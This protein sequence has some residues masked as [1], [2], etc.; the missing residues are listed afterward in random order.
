MHLAQS[1]EIY[2]LPSTVEEKMPDDPRDSPLWPADSPA[3]TS[4]ITVLQGIITR[5]ANNSAACK[6][7]SLTLVAAVLSVAG[8]T[9]TPAVV[10]AVII[11]VVIFWFL[12]V[13]YLATEEAYRGL[14]TTVTVDIQCRRYEVKQ[15]FKARVKLHAGDILRALG[16]WSVYPYYALIITYALAEYFGWV[17]ILAPAVVPAVH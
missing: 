11:P 8:S 9:R 5:L 4:H 12:D 17:N 6:T 10:H 3:A 13:M 2:K 1:D 15:A 16:S 7:W 14:Y